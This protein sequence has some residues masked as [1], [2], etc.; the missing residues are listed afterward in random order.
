MV[1]LLDEIICRKKLCYVYEQKYYVENKRTWTW[2]SVSTPDRN[3]PWLDD[4]RLMQTLVHWYRKVQS[5]NKCYQH[6]INYCPFS[7]HYYDFNTLY[8]IISHILTF[9]MYSSPDEL[10]IWKYRYR[11]W[12]PLLTWPSTTGLCTSAVFPYFSLFFKLFFRTHFPPITFPQ[13][14][15]L[16]RYCLPARGSMKLKTIE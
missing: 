1:I 10:L 3:S 15:M 8:K 2:T 14:P 11:R 13:V 16:F 4:Q 12:G 6:W 7:M 9:R 5:Q